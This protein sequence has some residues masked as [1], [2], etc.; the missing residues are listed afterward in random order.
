M[1]L[2]EIGAVV[3]VWWLYTNWC[4]RKF[5]R[6]ILELLDK[7]EQLENQQLWAITRSRFLS[8]KEISKK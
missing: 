3:G 5:Y 8:R 2:W 7:H 1:E 6:Q 4:R